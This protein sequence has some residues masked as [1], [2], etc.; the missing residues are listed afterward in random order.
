MYYIPI[1]DIVAKALMDLN[2]EGV[3]KTSKGYWLRISEHGYRRT[4]Y[5]WKLCRLTQELNFRE[6][7]TDVYNFVKVN[8]ME[9]EKEMKVNNG[10]QN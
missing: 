7:T 6:F 8:G 2:D 10:K 9:L 1:S 3:I 5:A 4:R